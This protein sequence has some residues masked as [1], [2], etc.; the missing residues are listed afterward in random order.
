MAA[1][2]D[3]VPD[4]RLVTIE[5]GHLVHATRPAEFLAEVKAFLPVTG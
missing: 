1:I 5:T 3:R 2:A 4:G